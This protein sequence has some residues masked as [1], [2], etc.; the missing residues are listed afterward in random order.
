MVGAL[1]LAAVHQNFT[2]AEAGAHNT[3][4]VQDNFNNA[5]FKGDYDPA[6]WVHVGEKTIKQSEESET[7]MYSKGTASVC[8]EALFFGT[9]TVMTNVE[10]IQFDIKFFTS[11]WISPK[12][13]KNSLEAPDGDNA[14]TGPF[15]I[16]KD[17]VTTH[18]TGTVVSDPVGGT[19]SYAWATGQANMINEW[20][21]F[22]FIPINAT[23]IKMC[24]ARQGATIDE[25]K[26]VTFG[27]NANGQTMFDYQNCQF[28]FQSEGSTSYGIDNIKIKA[29]GVNINET[30]ANSYE[31]EEANPLCFIKSKPNGEEYYITG[32]S[33][34]RFF[35]G[36]K[37]GDRLI[38]KKA[39]V[40]DTS[41]SQ[42]V[43]VIT[44]G[45]TV[46]F[47]SSATEEIAYVFGLSTSSADLTTCGGLLLINKTRALFKIYEN[48][49]QIT[50]DSEN[51]VAMPSTITSDNGVALLFKL[52][53]S[54][55][56]SLYADGNLIKESFE[57]P[58][59]TYIG[60]TGLLAYSDISNVIYVDD[61]TIRNCTYF[62]PTTKSVTHNFSNN[63]FGNPGY[64]DFYIPTNHSGRVY[65]DN[66]KLNYEGCADD[67]FFGS[68]YEYDAF[69]LD[70][71][72]C[73]VYVDS[74]YLNNDAENIDYDDRTHTG[75]S[76][77]IGLDCSRKV[78]TFNSYG[79]Y[80]MFFFEIAPRHGLDRE[81]LQFWNNSDSPLVKSDIEA[82]IIRYEGI[83]TSYFRAL[84]YDGVTK[85]LS[86]IKEEDYL[87]IRWVSD[88]SSLYLYL[89]TNGESEFTLY[90]KVPGLELN[91]Y[92]ALSNTGYTYLQ[93]DDFSM[94]NTSPLYTCADNE[95]PETI[96]V[97]ETEI[98]YDGA[99]PDVNYTDEIS[100]NAGGLEKTFLITTIVLG[101]TTLGL[102]AGLAVVLIKK[103]KQS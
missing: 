102:G 76:K 70:Y 52:Q 90:A 80:G 6:K 48:G 9:K 22:K 13:Y 19:G 84:Q 41:V 101:V 17:K 31:D 86:D 11:G 12:F 69:I 49:E 16:Q 29:D 77:W 2:K 43:N 15:L 103:K 59:T 63:F 50:T 62:V 45:F 55:A 21:T 40:E 85:Q 26:F 75:P 3:I 71:K 68:A 72:L 100:L 74:A 33:D 18:S 10:Y 92:F 98:I 93:Y 82:S 60:Y 96:T 47:P 61:V 14:Y 91:G 95:A 78:K 38:A 36:G 94:A 54:G 20:I 79:S 1:G 24:V 5:D 67:V 64:E 39:V 57:K 28:G 97:T 56:A 27:L 88:G 73:S 35:S 37:L 87:C 30:F 32:I 58:V 89:K 83:P 53:K 81:H 46:K 4:V 66:G 7:Y 42:T 65:A 99:N 51:T 44:A 25:T 8:G 34:L 23:Q